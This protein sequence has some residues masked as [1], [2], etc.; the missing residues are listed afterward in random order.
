V[1]LVTGPGATILG[2]WVVQQTVPSRHISLWPLNPFVD[3]AAV[4]FVVGIYMIVALIYGLPLP[5]GLVGQGIGPNETD[6]A[7][8]RECLSLSQ[9]MFDLLAEGTRNEPPPSAFTASP[10][11][12]PS[13]SQRQWQEDVRKSRERENRLRGLFIE[14]YGTRLASLLPALEARNVLTAREAKSLW[15]YLH[16]VEWM[17][18]IPITLSAKARLLG[19]KP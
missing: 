13:A 18:R 9:S 17:Q 6:E 16:S 7:V 15:F 3:V 8:G 5:G 11:A 1:A 4:G 10:H 19:V 2:V 12:D 14:R